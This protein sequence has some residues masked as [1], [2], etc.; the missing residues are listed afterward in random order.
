VTPGLAGAT[1]ANLV[2]DQFTGQPP[3][4]VGISTWKDAPHGKSA[5]DSYADFDTGKW[6]V[7]IPRD[8]ISYKSAKILILDD[9]VM[10][11]KF[12]ETLKDWLVSEG[13]KP[14]QIGSAS[15]A[16]TKMAIKLEMAPD[17]Y[18]WTADDDEF[19][20]PWGKAQRRSY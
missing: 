19:Y 2:S 6:L 1:I 14:E 18:W 7:S 16:V 13:M 11:G 5:T 3:V 9:F 8:L 20:W 17:F 10:S 12:L 4:Y 15:V